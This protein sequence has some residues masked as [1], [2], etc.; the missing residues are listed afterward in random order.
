MREVSVTEQR[1]KAVL[2]VMPTVGRLGEVASEW[3]VCRQTMRRWLARYENDGLEGLGNR[4][5]GFSQDSNR[6]LFHVLG[7]GEKG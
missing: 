5:P 4:M 6:T 7:E 1:Y 3:G 2:A